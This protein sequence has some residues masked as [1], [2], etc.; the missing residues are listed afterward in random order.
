MIFAGVDLDYMQECLDL[1]D[2]EFSDSYWVWFD[3]LTPQ[4]R[5]MFNDYPMDTSK[6]FYFNRI[7]KVENPNKCSGS[8]GKH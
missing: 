8:S 6:M 5:T 1:R 3:G 2:K 7:W 4:E